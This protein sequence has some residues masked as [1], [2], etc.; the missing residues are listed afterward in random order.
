MVHARHDGVSA[1]RRLSLVRC[2]IAIS[3]P[4]ISDKSRHLLLFHYFQRADD[5]EIADSRSL[6]II[7]LYLPLLSVWVMSLAFLLLHVGCDPLCA[8]RH[9]SKFAHFHTKTVSAFGPQG[10]MTTAHTVL[11]WEG[12]NPDPSASQ[13]SRPPTRLP[14]RRPVLSDMMLYFENYLLRSR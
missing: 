5:G 3:T 9:P 6:T 7:M 13:A 10:W 14:R 4:E 12:V 2:G 8:R 11:T 1:Q